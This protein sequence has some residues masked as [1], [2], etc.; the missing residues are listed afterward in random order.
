MAR[1]KPRPW[2]TRD[3]GILVDEDGFLVES[4]PFR[5]GAELQPLAA[6]MRAACAVLLGESGLGKSTEVRHLVD[7]LPGPAALHLDLTTFQSHVALGQALVDDANVRAWRARSDLLRLVLDGLDQGQIVMPNLP[8]VLERLLAQLPTDRLCLYVTCRPGEWPESLEAFLRE[9]FPKRFAVLEFAPLSPSNVREWVAQRALDRGEDTHVREA[10]ARALAHL[11][12]PT[13]RAQLVPLVLD[14]DL[15]GNDQDDQLATQAAVGALERV[16]REL[17]NE[18]WL[19]H[20]LAQARARAREMG[21]QP[22]SLHALAELVR[23][24]ESRVVDSSDQLF[25]VVTESLGR[26]LADLRG[27]LPAVRDLWNEVRPA[28]WL[29]KEEEALSD[30]VARFLRRISSNEES[31]SDVRPR[32]GAG[33]MPT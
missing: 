31:S 8:A 11:D 32:S 24:R 19:D 10:A 14:E 21:W 18:E 12:A 27:E 17:P 20:V 9:R 4:G 5:R 30:Y 6:S 15:R 33:R 26:L 23:R 3:T 2:G 25:D 1:R 29:P 16:R 28:V 13:A 7:Q 22:V